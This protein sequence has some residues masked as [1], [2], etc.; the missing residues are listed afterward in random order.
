MT[1]AGIADTIWAELAADNIYTTRGVKV[2]LSRF[3][4][5][6]H[7]AATQ[8]HTWSMRYLAMLYVCLQCGFITEKLMKKADSM[9]KGSAPQEGSTTTSRDEVFLADLHLFHE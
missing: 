4:S 8:T 2:S 9:V 7:Y 5:L 1:F 3:Q 6:A